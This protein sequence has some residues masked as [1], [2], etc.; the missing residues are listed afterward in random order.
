M[1]FITVLQSSNPSIVTKRISLN[2]QSAPKITPVAN[3]VRATCQAVQINSLAELRSELISRKPNECH[4]YG[5]PRG[6]RSGDVFN[7]VTERALIDREKHEKLI[8]RSKE[9]FSWPQGPGVLMLDYDAPR[10]STAPLTREELLQALY[11]TAPELTQ[12]QI[13]WTPSTTSCIYR[14]GEELRG[15][16][17]QRLYIL[18]AQASKIPEVGA[19]LNERLW[20]AGFGRHEISKS[21]Q[22]LERPMFD[23]S[24]WTTNHIDFCAGAICTGGLAQRRGDPLLLGGA[25]PIWAADA[26]LRIESETRV[27]AGKNKEASRARVF[28]EAYAAK[29]RWKNAQHTK[30]QQILRDFDDLTV[31]DFVHRAIEHAEL[32]CH[33]RVVVH[34]NQKEIEVPVHELIANPDRYDSALTLDPIEPDYDGRRTVGKLF[35]KGAQPNLY[36]FAHGGTNY[37]L[38]GEARPIEIIE[39]KE[40][41]VVDAALGILRKSPDLYD[42]GDSLVEVYPDGRLHALKENALK[43]TLGKSVQFKSRAAL[44]NPPPTVCKTLLE[45]RRGLKPL[46]AVITAPTLRA[47]GS[48]LDKPGYDPVSRLFLIAHRSLEVSDRPSD[49]EAKEALEILM[50]PFE[51]FPFIDNLA[52]SV[53][54]GAL[55]TAAI[56][57]SVPTAPAFVY[58]APTQGSGKSLLAAC[59]GILATGKPPSVWPHVNT[60][61]TDE[62]RKRMFTALKDGERVVVWDNVVGTFDSAPLAAILT[63]P[64]AKDR[65][66]NTQTSI[67][68]PNRA[69]LLLT[70]N[71]FTPAGDMARRVFICRIDPK[72]EMPCARQFAD[73][74]LETCKYNRQQMIYAALTL[75]RFYLSSGAPRDGDTGSF[76]EWDL[77]VRQAILYLGKTI[78]RNRCVDIIKSIEQNSQQDPDA[79]VLTSLYTAWLEIFGNDWKTAKEV[80]SPPDDGGWETDGPRGTLMSCLREL[81]RGSISIPTVSRAL[82]YRKGRVVD[83]LVLEESK[84][85]KQ[86]VKTWRIT[87]NSPGKTVKSE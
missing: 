67:E 48:V 61:N 85:L 80:A 11:A 69:L 22:I 51:H 83:G 3:V 42:F 55:L 66:L 73:N 4:I 2:E 6:N 46:D 59:V 1:P 39:G 65:L 44:R 41:Q 37:R 86:N 62:T 9:H 76:S 34:E 71:N 7:L 26:I 81:T 58:D 31:R 87:K 29:E 28:E 84:C 38:I 64:S 53:H 52:W 20:A 77:F 57:P 33:W 21:G 47:D 13:L 45:I 72:T 36:S 78:A 24:V 49:T 8:S 32:P 30:Y 60:Q 19:A 75:I 17:G 54:L 50:K 82:R 5:L 18:I 43:Y 68:V 10:D 79:E 16:K 63:S 74:P 56:R 70:G 23:A 12:H 40:A 27:K 35:L 15:I 25:T 14:E